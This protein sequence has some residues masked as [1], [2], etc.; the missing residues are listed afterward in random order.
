M[1]FIQLSTETAVNVDFIERVSKNRDGLAV[2]FMDN[3]VFTSNFAFEFFLELLQSGSESTPPKNSETLKNLITGT[4]PDFK[5]QDS[6]RQH[7]HI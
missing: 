2:V 1:K 5:P 3:K 7:E 4:D 6:F